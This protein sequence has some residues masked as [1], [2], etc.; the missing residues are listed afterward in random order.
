MVVI[1]LP[2]A[3]QTRGRGSA[4]AHRHESLGDIL[5]LDMIDKYQPQQL[6]EIGSNLKA[7]VKHAETH[8]H[9]SATVE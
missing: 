9:T 1:Y 5:G 4:C 8:I 6:L 2:V 3:A 7:Q